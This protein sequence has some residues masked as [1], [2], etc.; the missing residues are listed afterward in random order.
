MQEEAKE[1]MDAER[2]TLSSSLQ[3]MPFTYQV[4]PHHL[5]INHIPNLISYA[6]YLPFPNPPQQHPVSAMNNTPRQI[7]P[8]L[9]PPKPRT[10]NGDK[11]V[12]FLCPDFSL[13]TSFRAGR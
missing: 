12:R 3:E 2:A 10:T 6:I 1:A 7:G 4:F 9:K 5:R 13:A 8:Q 11:E